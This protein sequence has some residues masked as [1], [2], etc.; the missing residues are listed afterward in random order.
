MMQ[1]LK[2]AIA[3]LAMGLAGLAQSQTLGGPMGGDGEGFCQK[4]ANHALNVEIF[5]SRGTPLETVLSADVQWI[6]GHSEGLDAYSEGHVLDID[7]A[8]VRRI[9]N[10]RSSWKYLSPDDAYH[11]VWGNCLTSTSPDMLVSRFD[12]E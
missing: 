10:T 2:A 6:S 5:K 4:L 3:V 1:F 12:R 11:V 9:Y 8:M 7:T